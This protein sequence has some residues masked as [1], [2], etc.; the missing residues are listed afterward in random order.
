MEEIHT[1]VTALTK[2]LLPGAAQK[3]H[4]AYVRLDQAE[5]TRICTRINTYDNNNQNRQAARLII[6]GIRLYHGNN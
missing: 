5:V 6:T 1:L 3:L 4:S 2:R